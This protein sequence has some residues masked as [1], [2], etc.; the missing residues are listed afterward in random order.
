MFA[1]PILLVAAYTDLR[2]RVI[3]D[4]LTLGT[5][6]V[7]LPMDLYLYGVS[8][9][10]HVGATFLVAYALYKIGVWAGGDVK[11][12]TALDAV[13]PHS[14]T[15]FGYSAPFVL[16]LFIA[17]VFVGL[18]VTLFVLLHRVFSDRALRRDFLKALLLAARK[19]FILAVFTPLFGWAAIL[20]TFVPYPLDLF[21]SI[22]LL[23]YVSLRAALTGL[24]YLFAAS[25]VFIVLAFRTS[26]F[27]REKP[28]DE[29]KEGDIVADFILNDGSVVPFS[30]RAALSLSHNSRVRLSPFRAAGLYKDDIV[31]LRARGF[32]RVRVKYSLPFVP[33]VL[34]GYLFILAAL[35][36]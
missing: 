1:F 27:V 19:S 20:V 6:A 21:A 8:A 4:W 15:I 10:F 18:V 29:L 35:Y 24:A 11:L 25:L 36:L 12:F 23:P 9:L 30:W 33:F 3:P 13:Y 14:V 28:V 17:A 16:W 34:V 5:I 2:S 7:F 31:W 26:A 22:V 32:E